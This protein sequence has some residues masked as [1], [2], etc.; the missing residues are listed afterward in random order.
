MIRPRILWGAKEQ[1]AVLTLALETVLFLYNK[2]KNSYHVGRKRKKVL[3]MQEKRKN[4]NSQ[5]QKKDVITIEFNSSL[6]SDWQQAKQKIFYKL[7]NYEKQGKEFLENVPYIQF[8]DLIIVPYYLI[9]SINN[10]T[11]NSISSILVS[12]EHINLWQVSGQELISTALENTP[13]LFPSEVISINDIIC[14]ELDISENILP[15]DFRDSNPFYVLTNIFRYYG[16]GCMLY[17]DLLKNLADKLNNDLFIIPSSR[18][19][20][21][22]IPAKDN[23]NIGEL[24][25]TV[26]ETNEELLLPVL[27]DHVYI[28]RSKT[29]QIT[30]YK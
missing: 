3:L 5:N 22:I 29:N 14:D 16:A 30:N 18:D 6:F 28:F 13:K 4:R 17:P 27:S 25:E 19:E 2:I 15:E 9:E 12:Q 11:N 26:K 10:D 21:L 23:I 8:L 24:S 1:I 20:V 7:Y